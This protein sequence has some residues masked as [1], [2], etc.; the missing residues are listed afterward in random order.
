MNMSMNFVEVSRQKVFPITIYKSKV[1][2]NQSLK[3]L[4]SSK[5]IENSKYLE[6][7]E[8]WTTSKVKTS[9][10]GE[11]EGKELLNE[12][13]EYENLLIQRYS[14]C[15]DEIFDK[16]YEIVI[17]R[18]WYN[19]YTDGEYQEEHDHLSGPFAATHFSC[20]HFLSFD[21]KSHNPPEFRDPL[22]QLRNLSIEFDSNNCGEVYV[23][24]VE[25]GDL[26]MFPS[27]LKHWVPVSQKT[28]YPRITLSFNIRVLKYGN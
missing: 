4:L 13:S 26:L 6:I 21:P 22:S 15:M 8:D 12:K 1:P 25:E 5:I 20:I 3:S 23:P 7:P 2:N 11:P 28:D 18:I 10:A 27:Y 17:P 14:L 19:V 16:E 24:Q 9:F